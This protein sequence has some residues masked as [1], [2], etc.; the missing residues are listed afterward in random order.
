MGTVDM[1]D[2]EDCWPELSFSEAFH[3]QALPLYKGLGSD[4]NQNRTEALRLDENSSVL[5]EASW[6]YLHCT[7]GSECALWGQHGVA[8]ETHCTWTCCGL[9]RNQWKAQLYESPDVGTSRAPSV[10]VG[11]A[12][13]NRIQGI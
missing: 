6:F 7:L 11:K 9:E 5:E 13:C 8:V 3:L 1:T 4:R 12:P 10:W 2:S